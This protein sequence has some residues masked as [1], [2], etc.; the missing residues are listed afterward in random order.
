MIRLVLCG[1]LWVQSMAFAPATSIWRCLQ[2]EGRHQDLQLLATPKPIPSFSSGSGESLQDDVNPTNLL[3]DQS[4]NLT[5]T[6]YWNLMNLKQGQHEASQPVTLTSRDGS[7]HRFRVLVYP[8]GG[9]HMTRNKPIIGEGKEDDETTG[10]GMSY[11]VLPMLGTKQERVGVYVQYL[12]EADEDSVDA[13]FSLRLKGQ[14]SSGRKFDVEWSAGMR[15]TK[16]GNLKDGTASDFGAHLMETS[17]LENFMGAEDGQDN[18]LQIQL[19]LMTHPRPHV[20]NP[21]EAATTSNPKG[22]QLL[23]FDDIRKTATGRRH[24]Q[25][26]VR[27][28]KIVVPILQNLQ[29]RPRMFEVGAYPGVEY[30]ILRI[31]DGEN[32]NVVFYSEPGAEYELKPIYPLVDQLERPWPVR[33]KEEDI[34]KLLTASQYNTVSALGSLFTAAVGLATAFII[35]QLISFFVIPSRSMD[36]TLEVGDVLVVEKVTPRVMKGN[37]RKGDI[38]LFHPPSSLQ[39]IVSDSGG[40]ISDRDLFVKRVAAG[41][42][43]VVQVDMDGSVAVNGEPLTSEARALCEAE[44]L[45][46]IEKYIRS[47]K[48]AVKE[49]EVFVL[50]DCSSVSIDSR[51]WGSLE[52]DEVI[53]KPLFRVWPINRFGEVSN[54]IPTDEVDWKN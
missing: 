26:Q 18:P 2:I 9:G 36:P 30:R 22:L 21:E 29:Q 16:D 4:F 34:P 49:N 40:R 32:G 14:Q 12:P 50:G 54:V 48:T 15:F 7:Q 51:V 37:N 39:K 17:L 47:G 41:P 28:G 10:F 27:A 20:K 5:L 35:S 3:A 25:E 53:G 19:R 46:L 45:R 43:D 44:P 24:N 33:V 38:V 1:S 11:K 31:F 42:G 6:S 8:R 13:T 52:S 23:R